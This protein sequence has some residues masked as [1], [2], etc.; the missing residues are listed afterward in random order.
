MDLVDNADP[1]SACTSIGRETSESKLFLKLR[2]C[3]YNKINMYPTLMFKLLLYINYLKYVTVIAKIIFGCQIDASGSD[4][5][6]IPVVESCVSSYKNIWIGCIYVYKGLLLVSTSYD[7][8]FVLDTVR[9]MT[10]EPS[11][12]RGAIL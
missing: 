11:L 8:A 2:Q 10:K 9:N 12:R 3:S 7:D 1:K 4:I 6:I 5:E